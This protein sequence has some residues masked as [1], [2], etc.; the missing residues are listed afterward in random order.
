V[1]NGTSREL[2]RGREGGR[3]GERGGLGV[4]V[5]QRRE[6]RAG[7]RKWKRRVWHRGFRVC[8][9]ELRDMKAWLL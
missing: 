2:R 5:R 1:G 3:E 9:A 8:I 6:E 4:G 7:R